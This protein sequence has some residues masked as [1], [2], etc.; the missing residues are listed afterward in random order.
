MGEHHDSHHGHHPYEHPD[1]EF[2][3]LYRL[4]VT[5]HAKLIDH[6]NLNKTLIMATIQEVQAKVDELQATVDST[7][8]RVA[9]AIAAFEQQITDL[10]AIIEAGNG[11]T[12]D[13]LQ[14]LLT[15]LD[16]AKADLES[17]PTE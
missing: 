15:K 8:A 13:Q 17:T 12:P 16:A 11:A 4:I 14:D 2:Y 3:W 10:R 5:N 1:H 9:A 6:I 7:Q